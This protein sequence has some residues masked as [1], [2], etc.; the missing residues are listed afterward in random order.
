MQDCFDILRLRSGQAKRLAMTT[1]LFS[2]N[3]D[4]LGMPAASFQIPINRF[5]E[6]L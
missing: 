4:A 6:M 1:S 2:H 5:S 3:L